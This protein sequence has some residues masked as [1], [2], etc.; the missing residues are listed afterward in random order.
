MAPA[1]IGFIFFII[2]HAVEDEIIEYGLTANEWLIA[3]FSFIMVMGS[4]IFDQ[5]WTR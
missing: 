1:L 2:S 4:T 5:I 3:L